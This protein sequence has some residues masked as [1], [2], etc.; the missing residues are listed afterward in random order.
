MLRSCWVAALEGTSS[1]TLTA[2]RSSGTLI[3]S[4][5][6]GN[7]FLIDVAYGGAKG[8]HLPIDSPQIDQ[9]PDQYLSLGNSLLTN[10]AN[11]YYGIVTAPGS[12]LANSTIQAG[13]LLRPYPQFNGVSFRWGRHRQLNLRVAA[14]EGREALL[15]R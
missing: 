12:P 13:Q 14:G 10:V 11:P 8:T 2:T 15:G 9:L 1:I 4:G 5:S 7:G 6:S 3:S